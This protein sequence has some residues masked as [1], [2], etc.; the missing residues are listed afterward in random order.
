MLF[1]LQ[2]ALAAQ[3]PTVTALSDTEDFLPFHLP[4][5]PV[6]RASPATEAAARNQQHTAGTSGCDDLPWATDVNLSSPLLR[7]HHGTHTA[8]CP[9]SLCISRS[10]IAADEEAR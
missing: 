6:A 3:R 4:A 8:R 5:E 7:L 10:T 2:D 9:V 1:H